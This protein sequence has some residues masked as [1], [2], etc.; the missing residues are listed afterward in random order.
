MNRKTNPIVN[1]KQFMK[2]PAN[3]KVYGDLNYYNGSDKHGYCV[4]CCYNYSDLEYDSRCSKLQ[5]YLNAEIVQVDP[6]AVCNEF[7]SKL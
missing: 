7:E 6:I 5:M 4:N 2:S 3:Q 1:D